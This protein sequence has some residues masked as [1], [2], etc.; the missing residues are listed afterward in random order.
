MGRWGLL[1]NVDSNREQL[2]EAGADVMETTLLGAR[3]QLNAC[4]TA[5]TDERVQAVAC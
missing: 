2:Q 4:M 3:E 5:L 1:E